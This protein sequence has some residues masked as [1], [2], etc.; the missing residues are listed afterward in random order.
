MVSFKAVHLVHAAGP[1]PTFFQIFFSYPT[2]TQYKYIT[3]LVSLL[4][5]A[6]IVLAL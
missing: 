5:C 1:N 3:K 2:G 4:C 6:W